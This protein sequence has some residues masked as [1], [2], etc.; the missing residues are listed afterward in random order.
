MGKPLAESRGEVAYAASFIR[1]YAEEAVRINGRFQ[2]AENG[3][4]RVLTMQQPV[5]P[6]IFITPWNFPLAMGARKIGPAIAAGGLSVVLALAA[7]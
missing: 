1:W 7:S 2:V 5:G 4:F 3:A 6:C